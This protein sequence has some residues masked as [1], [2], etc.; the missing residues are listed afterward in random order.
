VTYRGSAAFGNLKSGVGILYDLGDSQQVAGV[1]VTTPAPG[2]T[3]EIR[4]GTEPAGDLAG[5]D[6][7]A[8]GTLQGTTELTFDEPVEARYVLVWVTGLVPDGDG[9]AGTIGEVTVQAAG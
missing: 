3:V 9:F 8:T 7:A 1:T 4:T 2:A 6:P 5:F